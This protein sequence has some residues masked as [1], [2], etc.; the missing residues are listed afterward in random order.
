VLRNLNK[1]HNAKYGSAAGSN[2]HWPEFFD[3]AEKYTRAN[4]QLAY[5]ARIASNQASSA[6]ETY[7]K[8]K[9]AYVRYTCQKRFCA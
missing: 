5:E 7:T 9:K 4:N 2:E 8:A 6:K 3:K 1:E